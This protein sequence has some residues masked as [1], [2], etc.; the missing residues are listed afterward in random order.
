MGILSTVF[1]IIGVIIGAGFAS[2]KEIYTFFFAYGSNG[3]LGISISI[4]LLGY[5]IYK[6]LK[7]IKKYDIQNYDEFLNIIIGN[8]KTKNLNFKIILNFI[9]NV[10]LLITFFVM[11]AGFSAYFKQEFGINEIITGIFVS[12][13]CYIFLNKDIKGVVLLN[14]ILIPLI[15]IILCALGVKVLGVNLEFK[16]NTNNFSWM[17]KAILYASYNSITLVSILIPMK[18]YIKNK[19]DILK[20]S[21]LCIL[22][23]GILSGIIF[24]L[25]FS[26]NEDISK[27]ELPTVYAVGNFGMIYKYMYGIIILG[28][29]ATTA[30]SSAY[31]FLNNISKTREK[32]KKYNKIICIVA[33]FI[34]LLGFSNLVNNL[35]PVFGA[36]GL[37]QLVFVMV[38]K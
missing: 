33:I 37:L 15:I 4:L 23:I 31:A 21:L 30:I 17:A 2:G 16:N 27:I 8:I 18:K 36:L 32:Y 1:V 12:I 20:I 5:I 13:I 19:K 6:T 9:I 38:S 25:L 34:S 35:Y 24:M 26:I 3:I 28:A 11:C 7:I 22:V 10:F 14:S 29:I